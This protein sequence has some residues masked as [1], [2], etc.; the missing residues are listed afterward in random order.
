M[1]EMLFL[2]VMYLTYATDDLLDGNGDV[3]KEK[4]DSNIGG[5]DAVVSV[6]KSS[7]ECLA[8]GG[9]QWCERLGMC[10]KVLGESCEEQT[11]TI[12]G[13]DIKKSMLDGILPPIL[14]PENHIDQGSWLKD[15]NET[16]NDAT[17]KVG[18]SKDANG[19]LTSAG[20]SWCELRSTCLRAWELENWDSEC[21]NNLLGDDEDE[22]ATNSDGFVGD[23]RD[24]NDCIASAGYTWCE[25][26]NECIRP[27]LLEGEWNEEC[28]NESSSS[29]SQDD[30]EKFFYDENGNIKPWVFKC[31]LGL[32][33]TAAVLLLCLIRV[34]KKRNRRRHQMQAAGIEMLVEIPQK[35][36]HFSFQ[37]TVA[38]KETAK[39]A[40]PNRKDFTNMV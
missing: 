38:V 29:S 7:A 4:L 17:P 22:H 37:E 18:G 40:V 31:F 9:V 12:D 26:K 32:T 15:V 14:S 21:T 16:E 36:E 34:R 24:D 5:T 39:E 28:T 33:I 8:N 19:C 3:A 1:K 2:G 35:Y 20:Y 6:I 10:L 27:W 25:K 13:V 11:T 30:V 23:D